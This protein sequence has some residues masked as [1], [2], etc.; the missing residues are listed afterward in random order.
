[1]S[2]LLAR[3]YRSVTVVLLT[4]PVL[5]RPTFCA[6]KNQMYGM[7]TWQHHM[8]IDSRGIGTQVNML[9]L[10]EKLQITQVPRIQKEQKHTLP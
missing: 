9:L 4:Y 1:V 7:D 5:V 10:Y 8:N 6:S 3:N 2:S